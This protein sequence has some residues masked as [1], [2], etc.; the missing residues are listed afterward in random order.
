MMW[1]KLVKLFPKLH[2]F[3]QKNCLFIETNQMKALFLRSGVFTFFSR[4][5]FSSPISVLQWE[6]ISAERKSMVFRN[7]QKKNNH[8]LIMND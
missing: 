2:S 8:F 3:S 1:G 6:G 4:S 5:N 7:S